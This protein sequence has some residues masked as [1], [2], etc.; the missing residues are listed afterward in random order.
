MGT[1]RCRRHFD[2][3]L[4]RIAPTEDDGASKIDKANRTFINE[5]LNRS[6]AGA[7]GPRYRHTSNLA[8]SKKH[9]LILHAQY[10][11]TGYPPP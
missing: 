2:D 10:A 8:D 4:G 7:P 11:C 6:L 9:G 3:Q 5:P 1:V